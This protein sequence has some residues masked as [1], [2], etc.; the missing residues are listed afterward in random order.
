MDSVIRDAFKLTDNDID[1][2][3]IFGN[4]TK[5]SLIANFEMDDRFYRGNFLNNESFLMYHYDERKYFEKVLEILKRL[6]SHGRKYDIVILVNNRELLKQSGILK[7]NYFNIF[8]SDG[9]IEYSKEEYEKEEE[10]LNEL[11]SPIKEANL[12]PFEKYLAVYNIVKK[13]KAYKE[14][15]HNPEQS[16]ELRYIL[17]NEYMTCYGFS[18]LLK[19]LLEKVGIASFIT[20]SNIDHSYDGGFAFVERPTNFE[21]H[22]HA[23]NVVKIDDDEYDIHGIYLA[24]STADNDLEYDLYSYAT[25]TFDNMKESFKL[26]EL[27]VID[28][29]MDFHNKDEFME[30]FNYLVKRMEKP[31]DNGET[32][33]KEVIFYLIYLKICEI[34]RDLDYQKYEQMLKKYENNM[35][36]LN[37]GLNK[38][39]D[40]AFMDFLNEYVEYM[41][42]LVNKPI[43]KKK[44]ILAGLYVKKN[45]DKYDEKMLKKWLSL[46]SKLYNA[47]NAVEF[48]YL[49]D[50]ENQRNNYLE[51][52]ENSG[53]KK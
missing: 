51:L 6:K 19:V 39:N 50:P 34:L 40:Q 53:K 14:N 35:E 3:A 4:H 31:F 44:I 9:T 26:E 32:F 43:D 48:P 49:Y 1:I 52:R 25:V 15:Y 18:K 24:D 13:F 30:K 7:E 8:I 5:I 38:D 42:P 37:Q 36:L 23:R 10:F 45:I 20:L 28:L 47:I 21:N 16:R 41:L 11:V 17:Y 12:T 2:F 29:L 27:K 22:G 46:T 33:K